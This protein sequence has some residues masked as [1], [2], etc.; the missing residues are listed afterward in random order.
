MEDSSNKSRTSEQKEE[1]FW[2]DFNLEHK[3]INIYTR[4][5]Y[6]ETFGRDPTEPPEWN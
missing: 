5:Q 3:A 2:G 6:I 4:E 1:L